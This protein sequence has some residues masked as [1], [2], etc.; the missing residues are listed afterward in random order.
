MV[1]SPSGLWK[2]QSTV[3]L[4]ILLLSSCS[5]LLFFLYY[6]Q[7][8][9]LSIYTT[10]QSAIVT[11][12]F[13][14]PV[15]SVPLISIFRTTS[16]PDVTLPKTTCLPFNH[17]VWPVQI[18]TISLWWWWWWCGGGGGKVGDHC[19]EKRSVKSRTVTMTI[20]LVR[21]NDTRKVELLLTFNHE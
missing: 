10:P 7:L 11:V 8:F 2:E 9:F 13:G 21:W 3:T 12:A 6:I 19:G 14:R 5:I 15:G 17:G 16:I 4:L 20:I 1:P 18:K